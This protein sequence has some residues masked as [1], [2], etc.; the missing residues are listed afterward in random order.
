MKKIAFL[1]DTSCTPELL[2]GNNVKLLPVK[3]IIKDENGI[4][5]EYDD[6]TEFKRKDVVDA[7][8]ND[9]DIKTSQTPY[10][11]IEKN[12]IN[13]LKEYERVY[14]LTISKTLSGLYNSYCKI[15]S[16]LD[17]TIEKDRL[18]VVDTNALALDQNFL[19]EE[20]TNWE[21]E[22]LNIKEIL[23]NI[24]DFT[25]RR[26]GGVI[27]KNLKMLIKNGRLTGFK[28]VFAK[29]F[30]LNLIIEWN[31][32]A[33]TFKDKSLKSNDAID[34]LIGIIQDDLDFKNKG[35]KK[36]VFYNGLI[37]QN[38]AKKR[39]EYTLSKLG[40]DKNYK[41]YDIEL[42]SL[43]VIHLGIDYFGFYIETN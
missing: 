15:K 41:Y 17:E 28:S 26:C 5:H 11:V 27:I 22:G 7:C 1:V 36:L 2:K 42:P 24:K 33:L 20:I 37:D 13:L 25:R 29:T 40:L 23:E 30:N 9:K 6:Y 43:I 19:I 38:E 31:N 10:G 12:I 14:C 8:I 16:K 21:K 4:E 18:I 35:I 34:R 32:G 39:I 3:V